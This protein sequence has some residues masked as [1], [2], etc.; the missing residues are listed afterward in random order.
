VNTVQSDSNVHRTNEGLIFCAARVLRWMSFLY[1]CIV[2]HETKV[3]TK[4]INVAYHFGHACRRIIHAEIIHKNICRLFNN[5]SNDTINSAVEILN[6]CMHVICLG[7]WEYISQAKDV[8]QP[9]S[10]WLGYGIDDRGLIRGS[11]RFSS[12]YQDRF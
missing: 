11:R 1:D 9:S 3:H 5:L 7:L 12:L 10:H 4:H 8:R 6:L 2:W